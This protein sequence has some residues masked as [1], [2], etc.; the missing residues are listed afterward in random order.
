M[1]TPEL[2][3]IK[4]AIVSG[5]TEGALREEI[6]LLRDLLGQVLDG[7]EYDGIELHGEAC[8]AISVRETLEALDMVLG[9]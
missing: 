3:P 7:Y 6:S 9:R 2:E 4:T 5:D 1:F 8:H